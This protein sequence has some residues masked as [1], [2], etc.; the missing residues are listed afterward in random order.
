MPGI[1]PV[2]ASVTV[3]VAPD[4]AF[5]EFTANFGA[6][7]PGE[8]TWS[9]PQLLESI[10][11]DCRLDGMLHE[12]GPHGFRLDWGRITTWEPDSALT[13]LWQI[14]PDRV[15]VPDPEQASIVNVLFDG[16]SDGTTVAVTHKSWER[17]GEAASS[18][19]KDFEYAW[20]MALERFSQHMDTP[21]RR[22]HTPR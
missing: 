8:F 21:N 10:G 5:H 15:P 7:W 11:M 6:W 14:G 13:F 17:H 22:A 20:P 18:Y 12:V 9:Q 3:P 4:S 16:D 1:E 2:V 19:R